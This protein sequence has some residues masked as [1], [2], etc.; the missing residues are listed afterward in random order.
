M[1]NSLIYATMGTFAVFLELSMQTSHLKCIQVEAGL[2]FHSLESIADVLVPML[3]NICYYLGEQKN[4]SEFLLLLTLT[5]P[6]LYL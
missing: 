4:S 5:I 3:F 2:S 6:F 1:Q